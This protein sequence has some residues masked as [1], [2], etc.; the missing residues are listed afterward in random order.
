MDK[1]DNI[2]FTEEQLP[3]FI[4]LLKITKKTSETKEET[5]IKIYDVFSLIGRNSS[6]NDKGI[7]K[8]EIQEQ[9]NI[10]RKVCDD[11]I[12][13]LQGTTLIQCVDNVAREQPWKI[14]NRGIQIAKYIKI[15]EVF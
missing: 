9:L 6:P 15:K 8:K 4:E 3:M 13:I 1:F 2:Y 10:S 5:Y 11:V 12:S 14:T 7:S